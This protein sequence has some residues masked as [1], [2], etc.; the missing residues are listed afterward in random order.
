MFFRK[1]GKL[2]KEYNEKL[3]SVLDE[4]KQEWVQQRS[5]EE[6]SVEPTFEVHCHTKISEAKYFFLF[7]EAKNR[8]IVIKR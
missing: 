4:A 5:I 2:R 1:K 8:K 7:R 6:M 3:I